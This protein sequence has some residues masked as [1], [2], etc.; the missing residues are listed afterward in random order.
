MTRT[1]LQPGVEVRELH[2]TI[3]N[4]NLRLYIKLP[5]SYERSET[6]Y[7]VLFCLDG[8]RSFP[9]YSTMSLIYETPGDNA[10]E[11]MIVGVGYQVD[12]D[13]LR[14]LAQWAAWRTRDLLPER[15]DKT[16]EYWQER[17][18]ALL[19]GEEIQVQ[20][21]GAPLF[22]NSLREEIIP[23]IEANY[24]VSPLDRGL[25]GYSYGGLFTL[26]ALF[27]ASESFTRY[28][29]GSPTMMDKLFEYE[30]NYASTHR[31]LKA[32]LF[33][34]TGSYETGLLEPLQR[35]VERL[36]SR[37]YPG[38]EVLTY[39]FEDEGHSSAYAASVSRALRMLY[40]EDGRKD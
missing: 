33:I 14:G 20:S 17:L 23:F 5:W 29:A 1:I 25:A 32:R 6:T 26:Y 22:L 37:M 21:G 28:F 11:I 36:R 24:R 13:R 8:N 16:E 12:D 19:G 4:Q 15:R 18:S 2:S 38:F 27:H 10:R 7:P 34:S 3:L 31:D 40:Y 30:E 35:M 9:L 39:V